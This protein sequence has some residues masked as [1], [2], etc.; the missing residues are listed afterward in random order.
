MIGTRVHSR[1]ER[2]VDGVPVA[3]GAAGREGAA[4]E[5]GHGV[6]ELQVGP[7]GDAVPGRAPILP[8]VRG[9]RAGGGAEFVNDVAGGP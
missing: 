4:D 5:R 8:R 7:V 3:V 2:G 6:V 1:S 9:R